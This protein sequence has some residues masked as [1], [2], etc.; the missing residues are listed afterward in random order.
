MAIVVEDPNIKLSTSKLREEL[1]RLEE[2]FEKV[3]GIL[4]DFGKM[5]SVL[6]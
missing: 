5:I 4:T 3:N 2:E 1:K 6:L